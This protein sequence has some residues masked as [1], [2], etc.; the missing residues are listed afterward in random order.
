MVALVQ[1]VEQRQ[2][3]LRPE[4]HAARRQHGH[5][6]GL[7]GQQKQERLPSGAHACR[8]THPMHVPAQRTIA[9]ASQAVLEGVRAQSGPR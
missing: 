3:R 8:P 4:L 6:A 7:A 2:Q 5:V 1:A 9:V